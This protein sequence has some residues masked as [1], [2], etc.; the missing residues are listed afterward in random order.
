MPWHEVVLPSAE[1][2]AGA[3]MRI[4][5]QF[6]AFYVRAGGPLEVAMFSRGEQDQLHLYFTP[7]TPEVILRVVGAQE[8]GRPAE[9]EA[10]CV[11]VADA[12]ARFRRGEF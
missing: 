10:L 7:A 8:C 6:E 1:V 5:N 2:A 3:E 9:V 12:I 4:M 11:G